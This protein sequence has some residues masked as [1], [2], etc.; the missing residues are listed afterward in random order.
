MTPAL[1]QPTES[2]VPETLLKEIQ[3]LEQCKFC[4]ETDTDCLEQHHIVPR[5]H[6]G[7]NKEDN[8]VTLC[9]SCHRKI[10]S[11]YNKRFYEKIQ[12]TKDKFECPMCGRKDRNHQ[13]HKE[14]VK[15]CF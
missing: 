1:S 9:A 2:T 5:R 3:N 13:I 7:T 12:E 4:N 10:E 15:G 6:G 11:L 14:H 8:L